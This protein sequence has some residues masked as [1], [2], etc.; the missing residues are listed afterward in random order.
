MP[1]ETRCL[2]RFSKPLSPVTE[3]L[4]LYGY[5]RSSSSWR[6]RIALALKQLPWEPV[7]VHLLRDGGEQHTPD[8]VARNPQQLVPLL[9]HGTFRLNQSLAICEYLDACW[10]TPALIPAAPREAARIRALT[11]MIACEIQ[12]LNNLRVLQYLENDL[13]ASD[14]ARDTWY[15][16]WISLGFE[17]LQNALPDTDG[18][19]ACGTNPTLVDVFLIPQL[20]N[21]RRF[22]TDLRNFGRLTA[23]EEYCLQLPAFAETAPDQQPEAGT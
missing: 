22:A 8:Y 9:E 13:G 18:P 7:P 3:P 19:Y 6:V 21:A 1:T 15:R 2:V 20:Y 11:Q 16:H 10:P 14:A 12:P 4:R 17:A 5:W 23:I